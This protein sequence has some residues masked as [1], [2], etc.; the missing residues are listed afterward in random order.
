M[1]RLGYSKVFGIGAPKTGTTSLASAL[2]ALGFRRTGWDPVL[3]EDYERGDYD[4]VFRVGE[5]Y[6][7]FEDG[8]WNAGRFYRDLDARFPRSKFVLT[9]RDSASWSRSHERHFSS[10]GSPRVD[11]RWWIDGYAEKRDEIVRDYEERNRAVVDYFA[12]RPD[13]LLV[14]DIS[15]GEGWE[16]LCPFL[17]LPVRAGRFP[18]RNRSDAPRRFE[19]SRRAPSMIL[20][21]R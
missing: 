16:K 7:A 3:V 17:G 8:P 6:E 11:A 19:S 2:L 18:H 15:A 20:P 4:P 10:S 9:V 5:R 12:G 13:D 1:R 21:S 14:L